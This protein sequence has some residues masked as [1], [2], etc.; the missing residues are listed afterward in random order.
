MIPIFAT[1]SLQAQLNRAQPHYGLNS[2]IILYFILLNMVQ[3]HATT[4]LENWE[5][6]IQR[7]WV[8]SF[9]RWQNQP[10]PIC[11]PKPT[12]LNKTQTHPTI[13]WF[14]W[15][16]TQLNPININ[17]NWVLTGY[18]IR[19]NYDLSIIS[20]NHPTPTPTPTPKYSKTTKNTKIP[21]K[22]R[23]LPKYP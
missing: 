11:P 20:I 8:S 5:S 21:M 4:Y 12:H 15:V 7:V 1:H 19:P 17:V 6:V 22:P 23:K 2:C 18:L 14:K 9:L 16:L 10:K 3:A 13:N